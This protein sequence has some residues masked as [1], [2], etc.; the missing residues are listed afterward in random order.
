MIDVV[1]GARKGATA[2]RE[3]AALAR[4]AERSEGLLCA[5]ENPRSFTAMR[6]RLGVEG[7]FVASLLRMTRA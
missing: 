6:A 1:H 4:H 5:A 7:S 2:R 3:A